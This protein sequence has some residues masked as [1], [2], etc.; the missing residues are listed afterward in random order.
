MELQSSS[1]AG[2]AQFGT[3]QWTQIVNAVAEDEPEEARRALAI[4]CQSYW[5]PL[6]AYARRKGNQPADAEDVTQGFLLNM[7]E[8]NWLERADRSKGKFRTFLLTCFDRYLYGEYDKASALKRGGDCEILPLD[9]GE[10]ES[11]FAL[12][13]RSERSPE[14]AYDLA[15][16][17]EVL[18]RTLE[19][20]KEHYAE[21][22]NAD[23]Y[24]ALCPM[25]VGEA[26]YGQLAEA[27]ASLGL[28]PGSVRVASS[29]M[30][31][32]YRELLL[33]E[34][35][36]TVANSDAAKEEYQQISEILRRA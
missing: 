13:A 31:Q 12:A 11:K 35:T 27:A 23:L 4:L 33:A 16:A 10:A 30:R 28:E 21:R 14:E 9:D 15:W 7:L 19:R 17:T 20:L 29:R 34:V 22:G 36:Q 6:Y 32:K 8:K 1:A 26:E 3:T 18:R 2:D 25:L 5:F 24:D